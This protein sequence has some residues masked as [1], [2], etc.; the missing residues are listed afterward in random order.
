MSDEEMEDYGFEYSEEDEPEEDEQIETENTYYSAKAAVEGEDY[1]GALDGFWKVV[2]MESEKGE[3][4]FKSYK[5]IVK[6]YYKMGETEKMLS[7]Y[8]ELLTYTQIAVTRNQ[9]E[10]KI[11]S[12]LDTVSNSTDTQLLQGFYQITLESLGESSTANE[13]LWFKTNLKLC[14][15]WFRTQEY[16]RAIRTLKDLHK[17]CQVEGGK[18]DLKKGTQLL[19]IYALEIQ[20]YTQQKNNKKLKELYNR[21]LAIKSAIPHPRIMAIIRECGGKMHMHDRAWSSAA[22]AFFE[23][24]KNY[25]EAGALRRIQCLKY[26]VLA[27][28]LMESDVDPFDAQEAKPYKSDPEVSAMTNLVDAYQR[29]NIT[30]FEKTLK[31]NRRTIMADSFISQYIEDL[32]KNIRTQVVLKL[33]QPYTRIRIPFVSKQLNIPVEDVEQLLVSLILDNRI[34]GRLDQVNHLLELEE[35]GRGS[36]KYTAIHSWASQLDALQ[37]TIANKLL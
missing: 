25:D 35:R 36:E 31:N 37:N 12:L 13:R 16:G 18:D 11:N 9:S 23:A 6:V 15:L 8:R 29:N 4:G 1:K 21:A 26:L 22:T 34:A 32:L 14:G 10:K 19:E 7:A 24:F 2:Q 17:S 30:E 20:I 28:M 5:Q 33:I 3:W 27:T